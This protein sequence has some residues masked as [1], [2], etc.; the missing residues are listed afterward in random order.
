VNILL[1]GFT[2]YVGTIIKKHLNSHHTVYG[3]SSGC[4]PAENQFQCDLTDRDS[5]LALADAVHPDVVI[6][7]A[8][9]KDIKQCEQNPQKAFEVNCHTAKHLAEA[10]GKQSRIIYISTDYVFSGQRGHYDEEDVP[11]PLTAYGKSKL[12]GEI[13]GMRIARNNFIIIRLSA[14]FDRHASFLRF[15]FY[16]LSHREAIDC[17][18]NAVYSPTYYKDFIILLNKVITLPEL[19]ADLFHACGLPT[20]RYNFAKTFAE[21]FQFSESLIQPAEVAD[22]NLHLYPDLSLRNDFT[23]SVLGVETTPVKAA[24]ED[25]RKGLDS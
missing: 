2:G 9:N 19:P 8:G 16:S 22:S 25:I 17:F 1:A 20:T 10:F 21:V 7:A 13:E 14:L 18:T 11:D 4:T 3:I 12:C 24:L 5:V 6:H 23:R 15:L